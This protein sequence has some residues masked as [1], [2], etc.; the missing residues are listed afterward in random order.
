M[1][2]FAMLGVALNGKNA[3]TPSASILPMDV[4]SVAALMAELRWRLL[5]GAVEKAREGRSH[6]VADARGCR[7]HANEA[8][9]G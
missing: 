4:A 6:A 1:L 7:R 8:Y 5:R 3:P 2:L 9:G